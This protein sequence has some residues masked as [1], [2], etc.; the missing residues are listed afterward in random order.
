MTMN[1]LNEHLFSRISPFFFVYVNKVTTQKKKANCSPQ[2]G[3]MQLLF[4]WLS[5]GEREDRIV[6]LRTPRCVYVAYKESY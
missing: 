4:Y 5:G 1:T 3:V 2:C 6:F